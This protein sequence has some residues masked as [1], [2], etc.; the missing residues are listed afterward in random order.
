MGFYG[1]VV[2]DKPFFLNEGS[3]FFGDGELI[4]YNLIHA[5]GV[6]ISVNTGKNYNFIIILSK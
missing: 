2:I 4:V 6:N 5:P 1:L 3:K